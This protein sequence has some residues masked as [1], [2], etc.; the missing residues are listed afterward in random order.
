M[1]KAFGLLAVT[2]KYEKY[3]IFKNTQ[4]YHNFGAGSKRAQYNS[5]YLKCNVIVYF[6][7]ANSREFDE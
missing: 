3:L 7:N 4:W 1:L 2:Q 6:Q 5:V